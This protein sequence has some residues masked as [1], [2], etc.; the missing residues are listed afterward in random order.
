MVNS[1]CNVKCKHCYLPY[2]GSR[3]PENTLETV[4]QL[5]A[6]GHSVVIAGS[7]TLLNPDYLKAY[8]QAEQ[9]YLLTNGILL[10]KGNSLYELLNQHGIEKL[11]FSIHFGIQKDLKSVPESLVARVVQESKR[12][13]FQTQVTTT[14]TSANY[15]SIDE[16]CDKSV[17]YGAD[18]IQ[19][20]RLVQIGR[21][22]EMESEALTAEQI[23]E[24]FGQ[25]VEVR[26]KY[27][28]EVLEIKPHGN[29]GPRPGSKGETLANENSYCPAGRD[30]VAI[31][32]QN[33]VYGCPFSMHP[34]SV[35]GRYENGRIVRNRELLDGRRDTCITHLLTS[36]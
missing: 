23:A 25:I 4:K 12:R 34:N 13:G 18:I 2:S 20:D 28:K 30:L 31:D 1:E 10:D 9:N 36:S 29:F 19:F 5:Q 11:T 22:T 21:G 33:R 26:K 8:Q 16:I 24:F 15:L 14:I 35:I 6:S 17:R 7:E 27:P 3:D 32:P